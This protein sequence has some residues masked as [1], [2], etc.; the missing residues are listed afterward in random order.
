MLGIGARSPFMVSSLVD[1]LL[2]LKFASGAEEVFLNEA[3]ARSHES[4]T[5]ALAR[6]EMES[7]EG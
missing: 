1:P 3:L 7:C 6:G 5:I 4:P 2:T